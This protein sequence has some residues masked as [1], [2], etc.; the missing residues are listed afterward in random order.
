MNHSE[1]EEIVSTTKPAVLASIRRYLNRDLIDMIDDVAQET[2]IRM[3]KYLVR[4]PLDQERQKTLG[5][6]AFTI[7]KNESLRANSQL[8]RQRSEEQ[9]IDNWGEV[10]FSDSSEFEPNLLNRMEY[11]EIMQSIPKHYRQV[12]MALEEGKTGSE[13]AKTLNI[14]P[15]TVKSRL[16]RARSY[17]NERFKISPS[18]SD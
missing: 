17:F 3:Y 12:L 2:Y 15:G 5:N 4:N 1:F 9:H 10:R 7:A 14:A 16:A 6:W 13:I 18:N 11:E 8:A